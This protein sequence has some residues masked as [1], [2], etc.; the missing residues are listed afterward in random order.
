MAKKVQ[1]YYDVLSPYSWVAFE[2]RQYIFLQ[3]SRLDHDDQTDCTSDPQSLSSQ[4]EH[5]FGVLPILSKWHYAGSRYYP[6]SCAFQILVTI[7]HIYFNF[8]LRQSPSW[9]GSCKGQV[10][11]Q[12]HSQ[13]ITILPDPSK[14]TNGIDLAKS[15]VIA[16]F[17][18]S[19][20]CFYLIEPS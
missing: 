2:V 4:V 12:R 20:L 15:P 8:C 17:T 3:M 1:I 5:Q 11:G 10:Y 9:Y 18:V 6:Q 14:I 13:T 7:Y 19:S 16:I